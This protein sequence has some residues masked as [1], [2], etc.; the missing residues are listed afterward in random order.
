[1][2]TVTSAVGPSG[3]LRITA[4]AAD[5]VV[6]QGNGA[7]IWI[8][9]ADPDAGPF[10]LAF[11]RAI[12]IVGT[13]RVG[14]DANVF[15]LRSVTPAL[16]PALTRVSVEGGGGEDT[17][18]GPDIPVTWGLTAFNSGVLAGPDL[19]GIADFTFDSVENFVGGIGA[20]T[21]VFRDG[22]G[23]SGGID[24]GGGADTLDYGGISQAVDV[25][26]AGSDAGGF[27]GTATGLGAGFRGIDALVGGT[28]SNSLTGEDVDSAWRLDGSATYVDGIATLGFSRFEAIRGGRLAD[29]FLLI[30][31][32]LGNLAAT[33]DGGAGDD[34]FLFEQVA[35]LTGTLDG[36]S[37]SDTLSYAG[38][39]IAVAVRLTGSDA[40]GFRGTEPTSFGLGEFRGIDRL[41]GSPA[42]RGPDA[43]TGEDAPSTWALDHVPSYGDGS[44]QQLVFSAFESLQG[45]SGP[46]LFDIRADTA[47]D[48]A[49]GGG[50]D[51]FRFA[52]DGVTLRGRI[53]GQAGRDTIDE[54]ALRAPVLIDLAAGT[55]TGVEGDLADI[56]NAVGGA[57][58]DTLIGDNGDNVLIGGAGDDVLVGGAGRDRLEG[59][60]GNDTYVLTQGGG[61]DATLIDTGG[62][63]SLD[64]SRAASGITIDLESP[65]VQAVSPG[66]TLRQVGTFEDFI[67]SAWPDTV[68]LAAS[69]T[70]RRIDGR[71]PASAPGDSLIYDARGRPVTLTPTS[72]SAQGFAAVAYAGIES[73]QVLDEGPTIRVRADLAIVQPSDPDPVQIGESSTYTLRITNRG[74]STATGVVAEDHLPEGASVLAVDSPGGRW[75]WD[76]RVVTCDLGTILP[77]EILTIAITVTLGSP[78]IHANTAVVGGDPEDPD[79]SNNASS[80]VVTV[81]V[82]PIAPPVD[83]AAPRVVSLRRLGYHLQPTRLVLTFSEPM[84]P[85]RA[86]D[87]RNYRLVA[88]GRDGRL[89]TR[90]DRPIRLRAATYDP[91]RRSVTLFPARRFPL[92]LRVQLTVDGPRAPGLTDVAGNLLDGD[93]DGPQGGSY[94]A[95]SRRASFLPVFSPGGRGPVSSPGRPPS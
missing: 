80:V 50:N 33:L 54:G 83:T 85:A 43:L 29:T 56:D 82:P 90:D 14:P 46:D 73:V 9:G 70:P 59:G 4:D 26:L 7:E 88:P 63:D 16:F 69:A 25:V 1:M 55:A 11:V 92:R 65:L 41:T 57:G 68:S 48:L 87:L 89:G 52:T 79:E 84:D 71:N 30:G 51:D 28:G 18:M 2:P 35:S 86:I 6:V 34:G 45:G 5:Q 19:G 49:G 53:D 3:L 22:A 67:G 40:D 93:G 81:R 61:S 44:A 15:D 66:G 24:G 21:F 38:F 60:E 91:A 58:D 13:A 8:N 77:G 12:E 32:A 64:F 94:A 72:I 78:G 95:R 42:D 37:G 47:A 23:L 17:L 27:R 39:D 62:E 76:G 10:P 36:G 75:N 31:D 20:D 74:P